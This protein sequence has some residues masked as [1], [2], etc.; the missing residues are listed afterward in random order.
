M[1]PMILRIN[2]IHLLFFVM[3][4]VRVS[5]EAGTEYLYAT[6]VYLMLQGIDIPHTLPLPACT[7]CLHRLITQKP[8]SSRISMLSLISQNTQT[9]INKV[10]VTIATHMRTCNR[11]FWYLLEQSYYCNCNFAKT[12]S[13]WLYWS[14]SHFQ[15]SG[16]RFTKM[17]VMISSLG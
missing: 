7:H 1:F 8:L 4:R 15:L 16:H 12:S 13:V 17:L 5:C 10:R 11:E 9:A 14:Y 3:K 6:Q 2:I